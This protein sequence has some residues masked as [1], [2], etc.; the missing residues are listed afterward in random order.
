MLLAVRHIGPVLRDRVFEPEPAFLN[1]LQDHRAGPGLGVRADT[2]VLLEAGRHRAAIGRDA[3]GGPE[4]AV[5]RAQD[6]DRAGN[7][8][9]FRQPFY[10]ALHRGRIDRAQCGSLG[11]R[12]AAC[13]EEAGG[14]AG[15]HRVACESAPV[16]ERQV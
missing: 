3:V 2:H 12:Y 9:F 13:R 11:A 14:C 10:R 6:D 1:L 8:H 7:E 15:K 16:L 5:R 4:L